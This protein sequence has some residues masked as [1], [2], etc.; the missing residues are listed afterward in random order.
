LIPNGQR[1][2]TADNA[3][4]S[5]GRQFTSLSAV[6]G[7]CSGVGRH[8]LSAN[9]ADQHDQHRPQ[10]LL[11]DNAL[12]V[13]VGVVGEQNLATNGDQ[14]PEM[15]FYSA[16]SSYGFGERNRWWRPVG[17]RCQ[18]LFGVVSRCPGRQR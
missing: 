11:P 16:V 12:A 9:N 5:V 3:L 13:L 7:R 15:A 6:V 10:P 2:T 1:W 14:R 4:F 18:P 17:R 8:M